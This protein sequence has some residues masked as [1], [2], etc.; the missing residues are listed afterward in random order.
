V[1]DRIDVGWT[2]GYGF[3]TQPSVAMDADGGFLVAWTE[4]LFQAGVSESQVM[5]RLFRADG[6]AQDDAFALLRADEM[7]SA[8]AAA[9]DADGDFVI[10]GMVYG[11]SPGVSI[12]AQR[13]VQPKAWT[14]MVYMDGD[15]S[16][17]GAAIKDFLEMASVHN[18]DVNVVVQFDRA[19]GGD[20]ATTKRFIMWEGIKPEPRYAVSELGTDVNMGEPGT[21]ERFINWARDKYPA[22]H[23]A[24]IL[25]DHG[26]GWKGGVCQDDSSGGDSLDMGELHQALGSATAGGTAPFD[27]IGMDACLMGQMEVAYEIKDYAHYFLASA[28]NIPLDGWDYASILRP[29]DLGFSVSADTWARGLVAAYANYYEPWNQNQTLM[30]ADL[31]YV[32]VLAEQVSGLADVLMANMASER[33]HIAYAWN[34]SRHYSDNPFD[35]YYLDYLDLYDFCDE[36][37]ARSSNAVIQWQAGTVMSTISPIVLDSYW[38]DNEY[39]PTTDG[40]RCLSIYFPPDKADYGFADYV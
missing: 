23:Y 40:Q 9:M 3:Y 5:G 2:L 6:T 29:S 22:E 18:S 19:G 36:L 11:N 13:F 15:N 31:D 25:W 33:T 24:L 14:V 8:P 37:K 7:L 20:W 30:A 26:G 28:E 16:L 35:P 1:G 17:K 4:G 38:K 32:G 10:A 39:K 21:L 34:A 27:V 12:V